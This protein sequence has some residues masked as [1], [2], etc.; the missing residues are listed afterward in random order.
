M[1]ILIGTILLGLAAAAIWRHLRRT[2]PDALPEIAARSRNTVIFM[3]PRIFA[4]LI[5][6]G[7]MAALLPVDQIERLFGDNS[8]ALG[9]ALASVA[10]IL[11]PG[12]PFVAF[13]IGASALKA[14]ATLPPMMAY[15]TAW[16]VLNVNRTL[17]YEI[18]FMGRRLTW[19]RLLA[20][21]PAPLLIGGLLLL[22]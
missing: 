20:S 6:A 14:G 3:V 22:V 9:V 18:P 1:N 10:G 13:A 15:I 12:G 11:T 4:G 16:S 7:F 21:I 19:I 17:T 8:G 5:G 2:N